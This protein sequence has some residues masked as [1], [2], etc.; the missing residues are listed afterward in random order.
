MN[1]PED[2]FA[3]DI[4]YHSYCCKV[5]FNKYNADIEEVLKTLRRKIP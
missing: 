1:E 5:Y 3:A 2:V 4:Y